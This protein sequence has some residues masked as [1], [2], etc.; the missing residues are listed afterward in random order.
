MS[1]A[2]SS[3]PPMKPIPGERSVARRFWR[4]RTLIVGAG[5]IVSLMVMTGP[6]MVVMTSLLSGGGASQDHIWATNGPVYLR[7]SV[8]LCVCVGG[9]AGILGALAASLVSLYRFPGRQ[10]FAVALALPFA[11]PAYIS[12]YAYGDFLSPFGGLSDW[13]ARIGLDPDLALLVPS[14]RSFWGAVFILS[15]SVYPY[16]YLAVRADLVNRSSA[17]FDAARSLGASPAQAIWR[18]MLP[19]ARIAFVGGLALALM[20]TVA[21]YGVSDYF[22]VRTLTTGI[23]RTWYGLSDLTAAAQIAA[24]LFL[25]ALFLLFIEDISRRG[26]RADPARTGRQSHIHKQ[27]LPLGAFGQLLAILLCSLPVC[28]GFILPV[29]ILMDLIGGEAGANRMPRLLNAAGNTAFLASIG[30]G[31]ILVLSIGLAYLKRRRAGLL[32]GLAL[33]LMTMGYAIPGAVIAIGI[34]V[35]AT[36]VLKPMGL[37]LTQGGVVVLL[38]AYIIRFLTAGYN[39]AHGGLSQINPLTDMAA[40]SLGA[41]NLRLLS[42]V[43]LP[44]MR[45]AL[46]SGVIIVIIDISR[47]LPATLLLRPFNFET[48]ATQV[49]RLASDERLAAAA[50]MALF[51]IF[52]GLVPVLLLQ[53]LASGGQKQ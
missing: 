21:D 40:H 10:F 47:E 12:A 44:M 14:I 30:A 23:F 34:L 18:V 1:S 26:H 13:L 3:I 22:G 8:L 16:V 29:A 52:I 24:G 19:G 11:V 48:L 39:A 38:Y 20:E 15:L 51:L 25:I 17:Y 7:G 6:I 33:R 36:V 9:V 2:Y 28:F 53:A 41:G 4:P 35:V 27:G 37:S 50:P 45:P 46:L 43:H 5:L 32:T 31:A 42:H 49:Y